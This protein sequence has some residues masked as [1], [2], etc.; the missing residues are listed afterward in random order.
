VFAQGLV[1]LGE[2]LFAIEPGKPVPEVGNRFFALLAHVLLFRERLTQISKE[3]SQPC[4]SPC[5]GKI[6]IHGPGTRFGQAAGNLPHCLQHLLAQV[7]G[8][9]GPPLSILFF[10]NAVIVN[11]ETDAFQTRHVGSH[12]PSPSMTWAR[13]SLFFLRFHAGLAQ[14]YESHLHQVLFL[15]FVQR[16][17]CQRF[18]KG[19]NLRR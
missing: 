18:R 19:A 11:Q 1:D 16:T 17:L 14:S 4:A 12:D 10:P 7:T 8:K 2:N 3:E 5:E 9:D 13:M 15:F 6:V